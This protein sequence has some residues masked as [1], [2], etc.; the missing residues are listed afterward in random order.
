MNLYHVMEAEGQYW[1]AAENYQGAADKVTAHCCK[2]SECPAEDV[3]I[4][5][6]A[7]VCEKDVYLP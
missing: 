1:V 2:E 6:V 3:E 7:L 4:T 5:S